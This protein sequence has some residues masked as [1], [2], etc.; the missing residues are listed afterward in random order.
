MKFKTVTLFFLFLSLLSFAQETSPKTP[1]QQDNS[2]KGQFDRIYRKSTSYKSNK[3]IN[4][5]KYQKLKQNVLDS[6]K[7]SQQQVS[8][9]EGLLKIERESSLKIQATLTKT[10]ADLE[11]STKKENSISFL[12]IELS[13][14][15]YN[16][17]L[18][19]LIF[20]FVLAA[21]YFAYQYSKS[22][23]L[24]KTAQNN[25]LNVE[26]EYEQ[27]KK[28]ALEREQRLRREL[29]DEINKHRSN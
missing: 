18:G 8:E 5:G 21:L 27:Y 20:I 17:A 13:K 12:G 19:S 11:V 23:I 28:K 22:N 15:T 2:L 1:Q 14:K 16:F 4:K 3:V 24:T 29:Q 25:L 26:Q 7:A 6:L 10:Q 9:K